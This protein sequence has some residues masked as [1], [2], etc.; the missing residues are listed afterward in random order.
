MFNPVATYRI[1]FHKGFTFSDLEK[2]LPY[3]I[4]LGISTIYASPIFE[5][6]PGSMH[7]YDTVNPLNINPEIGT[8]QQLRDVSKKLKQA[9]IGWLQDIVPNHMAYH[10]NNTWLM[11]VLEKGPLSVY[12]NYFDQS[13]SGDF[14]KGPIM[15]PFLGSPLNE[16]IDNGDLTVVWKNQQL[17]FS[18]FDNSW[19]LQLESYAT[20]FAALKPH[21][22][23]IQK[24]KEPEEFSEAMNKVKQMASLQKNIP[25]LISQINKDKKQLANLANSQFYRLCNWKETDSQI[26]YRRFFTVNSLIC[27]NIHKGKVFDHFHQL[28]GDLCK[29]GV[30]QGL[31]IDHIDG[32][33]N[34]NQYLSD[35]R[36]LTGAE[37]YIVVEKILEQGEDM[38]TLWPIQGSTG[39]D[40]LSIVNNL[41]TSKKSRNSFTRF[42]D[43]LTSDNTSVHQ[44][45][46]EKK[47]YILSHHMAGELDN[48]TAFFIELELVTTGEL[49][50][51]SANDLKQAIAQF[52][53]NCP[54]Y[55]YY[56]NQFP[57]DE[58]ESVAVETILKSIKKNDNK[59][60][61]AAD[62]LQEIL[63]IKPY[64]NAS[65]YNGK[66]LNF[67]RRLMQFT[68]PLMAKG[69]EDTLMYTYN[70][71]INHNE[72]GDS[73]ETFGISIGN[74]HHQMEIRQKQWPLA[75]NGTS[76]HDTKRGEDVRAR[77]N[78]LSDLNSDWLNT[79]QGW[80]K[81]NNNLKQ[82]QVPNANDELF[83]YQTLIGAYPMPGENAAN[84][85]ERIQTYL[86]KTL[87][88]VKQKSDWV[89]PNVDYENAAKEFATALL[90]KKR[91]FWDSFKSYH[92]K[93]ADFGIV[94]SL[95]QT[96]L[97]FTC[98]G[99]PDVY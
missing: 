35:L 49:K 85:A 67:Y 97:K 76:T 88:E 47:A 18:Y 27:L 51:I 34:P 55:K 8:L 36:K 11:D 37:T 73:P 66:A 46:A 79:L 63:L 93:I 60:I 68:G 53:I 87:R 42:Y 33:Y 62:L 5:A 59:L 20:I 1:Q 29:E 31:R 3:L 77:L 41:F 21:I 71:F 17:V 58:K 95:A 16:A 22:Q 81:M 32:L 70:R 45:I 23:N 48:L 61:K 94:N 91:R 12:K 74:F 86:E 65:T 52:L 25:Q 56:G 2:V 82:K 75:M 30:F 99:V 80:M 72:V 64:K 6:V 19:P 89:A 39:Y 4:E 50:G 78:V 54:V 83:I 28:I 90:N 96:L 14:Y 57:L 24:L 40:Y 7:G 26:N 43:Q 98:P 10:A 15:A 38:P 13:L 92:Q 84:F 69:V 9:G 44:Q